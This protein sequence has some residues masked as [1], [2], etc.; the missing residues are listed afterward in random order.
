MMSVCAV[1]VGCSGTSG[2]E[3]GEERARGQATRLD[4]GARV[5]TIGLR[6]GYE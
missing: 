5:G 2:R 3:K 6:P 1:Q 4:E